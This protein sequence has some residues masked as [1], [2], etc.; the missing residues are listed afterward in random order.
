VEETTQLKRGRKGEVT[1]VTNGDREGRGR[2]RES[3]IERGAPLSNL[4]WD[5]GSEESRDRKL[6]S[7][8][9]HIPP[10]GMAAVAASLPRPLPP[11]DVV[12]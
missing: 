4:A 6:V 3:E 12:L 7:A 5:N 11:G 10:R 2:E 1:G 8:P 9:P